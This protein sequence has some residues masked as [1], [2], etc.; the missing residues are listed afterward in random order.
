MEMDD[1]DRLLADASCLGGTTPAV[2][3]RALRDELARAA[4]FLSYARH[5]LSVD[6]G[7]L[8]NVPDH[9]DA[10]QELIDDLPRILIESSIGGGWSLSPD[11]QVTLAAADQAMAGQA[12]ALMSTHAAMAT[13]DFRSRTDV[14]AAISA[15]DGQLTVVSDRRDQVEQTLRDLQSTL[16]DQYRSGAAHVDDWLE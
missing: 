16:V 11:S 10:L 7:I 14:D 4:V 9:P 6:L 5:V 15:V 3:L 2:H 8:R 12:G 13:T 1:I